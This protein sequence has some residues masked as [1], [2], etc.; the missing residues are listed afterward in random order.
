MNDLLD[1]IIS[2][3]E[4]ILDSIEEFENGF[5]DALDAA[6]ERFSQFTDTLDHNSAI[7]DTIKEIMTL[8]GVSL[9]TA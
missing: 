1:E 5:A 6:S 8:Q 3:G 7:S 9:K 2:S 4:S